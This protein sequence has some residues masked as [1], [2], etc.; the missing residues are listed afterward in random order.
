V[1][2]L[3]IIVC[4]KQVPHPDEAKVDPETGLVIRDGVPMV[5]N[6]N[7]YF[8]IEESL[9]LKE[10]GGG[11][12]V[13]M[14][15]G[16]PAAEAVLRE[17]ISLGVDDGVL[18]CHRSFAGADTL[19]TAYAL[20]RGIECLG[21][22]DLVL[23]GSRSTDGETG[24]VG[25]QIAE[26]LGIPHAAEL[27]RPVEVEGDHLLAWHQTDYGQELLQ[28]P[29]PALLTVAKGMNEPRLPSLRGKMRAKKQAITVWGPEEIKA[30][31]DRIGLAGSPTRMLET[32]LPARKT[33]S[34]MLEG[35]LAEQVAALLHELADMLPGK[36]GGRP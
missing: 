26:F 14:T 4:I 18:L 3:R 16:P 35:S 12:V 24:Q 2:A 28:M 22:Y 30:D 6:P 7:D 5:L 21:G 29:L 31:P 33:R 17:A 34:K 11:E 36:A 10:T 15:M 9:R 19:A 25:P 13:A 27:I 8:A 23:T 20:A 32:T 1:R